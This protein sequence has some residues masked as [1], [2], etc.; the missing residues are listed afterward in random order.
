[1]CHRRLNSVSSGIFGFQF[2]PRR[3]RPPLLRGGRGYRAA[4]RTIRPA[5]IGVVSHRDQSSKARKGNALRGWESGELCKG[6]AGCAGYP[7][8]AAT[9]WF[10]EPT[11]G[12]AAVLNACTEQQK[13]RAPKAKEREAARKEQRSK[14]WHGSRVRGGRG[15]A[16]T[17]RRLEHH[18]HA[19][20]CRAAK[21]Q[22]CAAAPVRLLLHRKRGLCGA[23]A[24]R[25]CMKRCCQPLAQVLKGQPLQGHV[26]PQ[27]LAGTQDDAP[28]LYQVGAAAQRA[29]HAVLPATPRR[30]LHCWRRVA[31]SGAGVKA[32]CRPRYGRTGLGGQNAIAAQAVPRGALPSQPPP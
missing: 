17:L 3:C 29:E 22:H 23:A 5:P 19:A 9:R 18:L 4:L 25:V 20:A 30:L 16:S 24:L 28:V 8:C 2:S 10:L 7:C 26:Q 13:R 31:C 6:V 14:Q 11:C 12:Q 21:A 27:V 1:M 32:G 15:M